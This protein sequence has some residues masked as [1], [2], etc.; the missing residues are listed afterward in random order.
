M[1]FFPGLFKNKI[2]SKLYLEK[3]KELIKFKKKKI[4]I[5]YLRKIKQIK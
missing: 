3:E 4:F 5:E 1:Q 2:K